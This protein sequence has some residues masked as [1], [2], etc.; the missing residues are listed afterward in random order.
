MLELGKLFLAQGE[1]EEARTRLEKAVQYMPD[2]PAVHY[3]LGLLYRR[4]GQTE[5]SEHHLRLSKQP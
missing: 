4:L 5:K 3:Q 2:A 1:W